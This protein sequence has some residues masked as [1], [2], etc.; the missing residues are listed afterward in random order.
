[1]HQE[2]ELQLV[3]EG[4]ATPAAATAGAAHP[5]AAPKDADDQLES[6]LD[7]NL[8]PSHVGQFVKHQFHIFATADKSLQWGDV[9]DGLAALLRSPCV[10]E[11]NRSGVR[12]AWLSASR[13]LL[14]QRAASWEAKQV[15]LKQQAAPKQEAAAWLDSNK[16]TITKWGGERHAESPCT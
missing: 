10:P 11:V 3:V 4:E 5:T 12:A 15:Q 14:Q 13:V 2:L 9:E 8:V 7:R 1:M 16:E 6:D